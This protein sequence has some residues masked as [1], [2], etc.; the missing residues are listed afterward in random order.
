MP[1][2]HA[3]V[4][5]H[6]PTGAM[7]KILLE[8]ISDSRSLFVNSLVQMLARL[9]RIYQKLILGGNRGVAYPRVPLKNNGAP[10]YDEK[11]GKASLIFIYKNV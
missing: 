7:D 6:P 8:V 10:S 11:T 2:E 4:T 5:P 1:K 9:K 3:A